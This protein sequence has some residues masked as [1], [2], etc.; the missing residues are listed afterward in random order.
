MDR[1]KEDRRRRD[2]GPAGARGRDLDQRLRDSPGLVERLL[3]PLPGVYL[4]LPGFG[5]SGGGL[6]GVRC[7]GDRVVNRSRLS[8][9]EAGGES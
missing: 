9:A 2:R 1:G 6:R 4:L 7:N 3:H 5:L 8:D